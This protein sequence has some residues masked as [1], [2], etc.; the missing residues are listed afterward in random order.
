MDHCLLMLFISFLRIYKRGNRRWARAQQTERN[1][2]DGHIYILMENEGEL[3]KS[4][5][6]DRRERIYI[7]ELLRSIRKRGVCAVSGSNDI[8][9]WK[10]KK[11]SQQ[12]YTSASICWSLDENRVCN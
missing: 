3:D 12:L 4:D 5:K 6:S 10:K 7:Y 9:P 2:L 1:T 11:R 8:Q